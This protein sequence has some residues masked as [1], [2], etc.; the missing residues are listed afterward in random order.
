MPGMNR[1]S[2]GRRVEDVA[3]LA[4]ALLALAAI[5]LAAGEQA[6]SKPLD[7][8]GPDITDIAVTPNPVVPGAVRVTANASDSESDIGGAEFWI[9][10]PGPVGTSSFRMSAMDTFDN[11]QESVYWWGPHAFFTAG[12]RPG[13][14][15]LR[16]HARDV[17]GNWGPFS[18]L[19][20]VVADPA[21]TGPIVTSASA[22]PADLP[23]GADLVGE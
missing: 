9:D 10:V 13:P 4:V 18:S 16:V 6:S 11:P 1:G 3:A 21:T 15:N 14:H 17:L 19:L 12:I 20:F 22:S 23:S 7:Q 2:M 5:P 8:V